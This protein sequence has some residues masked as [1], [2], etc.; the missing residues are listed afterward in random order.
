MSLLRRW[1]RER[2]LAKP[3]PREWFPFLSGI[4]IFPVL[5]PEDRRELLD[6]IKIFLAEKK[7]E[8][9]AG[10]SVD[11]AARVIVAGNASLLLLHRT[12]EYFP[13]MR[14]VVIYPTLYVARYI[15]ARPGGIV[16]EGVELRAGESWP[17]GTVVLAWDA[18][19]QAGFG[20][21]GRNVVIHEFAHQ[22]DLE[23]GAMQGIPVLPP[24]LRRPWQEIFFAE[25]REAPRRPT[26]L[27][28]SQGNPAEF[29]ALAVELFFAD[30]EA[31]LRH[32]PDLYRLLSRYFRQDP[33]ALLF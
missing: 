15:R 23:D 22:L 32:H 13:F 9:A 5:P 29:F 8:G 31:L 24:E 21:G 11:D 12:A 27:N 1:R 25:W 30:P 4:P 16:E 10:F 3:F 19:A 28:L 17:L 33:A 20:Q 18:V 26:P 2:L 6:H 7:F 14:T